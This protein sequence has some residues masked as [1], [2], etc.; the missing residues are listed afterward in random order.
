MKPK[1]TH[2]NSCMPPVWINNARYFY[3][4][5]CLKYYSCDLTGILKEMTNEY[6]ELQ[7]EQE[8]RNG[9]NVY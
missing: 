6:I 9:W 7:R 4:D 2:C 3:C 5:L 1:C 8:K